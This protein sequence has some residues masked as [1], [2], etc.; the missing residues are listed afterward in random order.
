M[1][2]PVYPL[3]PLKK[4]RFELLICFPNGIEFKQL[5]K[6]LLLNENGRF[7]TICDIELGAFH[8]LPF[9]LILV[10]KL[11]MFSEFILT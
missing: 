8:L 2:K 3:V 10:K 4:L 7:T 1:V 5:L 6:L 11:I 9:E